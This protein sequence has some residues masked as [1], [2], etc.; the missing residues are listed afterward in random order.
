MRTDRPERNLDVLELGQLRD[1]RDI[2][3]LGRTSAKAR[4][5]LSRVPQAVIA[6]QAQGHAVHRPACSSCGG[7]RSREELTAPFGEESR[8]IEGP[9]RKRR[10]AVPFPLLGRRRTN[11]GALPRRSNPVHHT[12]FTLGQ[13]A[14]A[15]KILPGA[16]GYWPSVAGGVRA[17]RRRS[18]SPPGVR[19]KRGLHRK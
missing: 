10:M 3:D 5:L 16:G 14:Q 15:H 9:S 11:A 2:A 4:Q 19:H 7:R 6:A 18:D 17:H 1:L 13:A 8:H 12:K